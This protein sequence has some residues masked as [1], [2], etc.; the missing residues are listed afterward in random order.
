MNCN[1][2][3]HSRPADNKV[4]PLHLRFL[5]MIIFRTKQPGDVP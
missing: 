5:P 2:E 1:I 3:K 4:N